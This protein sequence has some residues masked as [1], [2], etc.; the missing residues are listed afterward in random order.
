MRKV[1]LSSS[2][3]P[4]TITLL[5]LHNG[6]PLSHL[7][8]YWEALPLM[9]KLQGTKQ[10]VNSNTDAGVDTVTNSKVT[11]RKP[12]ASQEVL[13]NSL[14][15][16]QLKE[17]R[18]SFYQ[19]FEWL[20]KTLNSSGNFTIPK[21]N[22]IHLSLPL[23]WRY[24]FKTKHQDSGAHKAHVM[25]MAGCGRLSSPLS[26]SPSLLSPPQPPAAIGP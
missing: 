10:R 22:I 13:S 26:S 14:L 18:S 9:Q 20:Y 21:M 4:F 16:T 11:I 3:F 15:S 8:C 19:H 5:W 2:T 24:K 25:I 17:D 7:E 12:H 1:Q 6:I 23:Y